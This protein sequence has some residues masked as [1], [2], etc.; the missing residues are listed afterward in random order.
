M[1]TEMRPEVRCGCDDCGAHTVGQVGPNGVAGW[2]PNCGS[3]Q[4]TPIQIA[5]RRTKL[6][7]AGY[8]QD[9]LVPAPFS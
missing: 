1:S 8:L 9:P 7:V 5:P 6:P 2:C 4:V 3:Y